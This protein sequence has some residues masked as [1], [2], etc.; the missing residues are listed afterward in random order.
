MRR[1]AEHQTTETRTGVAPLRPDGLIAPASLIGRLVP[2]PVLASGLHLLVRSWRSTVVGVF[3]T[4]AGA[5]PAGRA[6]SANLYAFLRA[7]RSNVR[8]RQPSRS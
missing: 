8:S 5:S 7:V 4:L 6:R 3:D 1:A 2:A